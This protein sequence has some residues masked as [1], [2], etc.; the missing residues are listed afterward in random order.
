MYFE[1]IKSAIIKKISQCG[2]KGV[3]TA[4]SSKSYAQ[5][6][7]AAALLA[8]GVSNIRNVELCDDAQNAIAAATVLGAAITPLG[9]GDYSIRGGIDPVGSVIDIGESGLAAR[10]FIP[11]ASLCD[12]PITVTGRGSILRRPL[13]MVEEPLRNLG[14]EVVSNGGM[15]PVVVRGPL[16]GG[17]TVVDGSTS[18]QFV[19]GL[20]MALP[21]AAGDTTLRVRNLNS[22]PYVDMTI[23]LLERFG[24]NVGHADYEEFFIEGGQRYTPCDYTV[25]G[26][27]SGASCLL[28]AGA[29]AGEV[30]IRNLNPLSTQADA[31]IIEALSRCGASIVTTTD[32]VT[33][34]R[35]ELHPF[36]F[37]ATHCPDLFPALA[38]LAACCDGVSEIRGAHRLVHKESNRAQTIAQEFGKLGITIEVED[39]DL[40]RIEGRVVGTG[41]VDS[42]NDHRIAM[43]LAILG[44]RSEGGIIIGGAGAVAKSYPAFWADLDKLRAGADKG[45]V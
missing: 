4:P 16:R 39:G 25:E 7:I 14:V 30:T 3:T 10:L 41:T 5:R 11:I 15:L 12:V 18:S 9:G 33:V 29:V 28:V 40:M 37:D 17:E 2:V 35:Q 13:S 36:E 1:M 21:L 27:W 32:S 38:A 44:L 45:N 24:V 43:A 23:L 34:S 26:D 42:H 19:S 6:A 8:G 31:A 20:L 22:K